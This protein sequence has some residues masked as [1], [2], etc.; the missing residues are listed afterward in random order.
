MLN[1]L[2]E[3][4]KTNYKITNVELTSNFKKDFNLTSFDFINLICLIEEK[5]GVVI[6]E[7]HYLSLNTIHDI[8][9]HIESE[10]AKE[11]WKRGSNAGDNC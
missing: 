3:I 5:F 11:M 6:E 9:K 8:I 2:R 10:T 4:L 1:E 7:E